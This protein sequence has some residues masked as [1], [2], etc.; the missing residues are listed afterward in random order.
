MSWRR[1]AYDATTRGTARPSVR[2]SRRSA[3][4]DAADEES[5]FRRLAAQ[6]GLSRQ[7]Q[8]TPDD[9]QDDA[10]DDA[11]RQ[12]NDEGEAEG[13][14]R[15]GDREE[16][17]SDFVGEGLESPLTPLR[18][19][20]SASESLS[21]D[22]SLP[23]SFGNYDVMRARKPPFDDELQRRTQRN[24]ERNATL[25]GS[26]SGGGGR[27]D[28]MRKFYEAQVDTI[29]AQLVVVA[30]AQEHIET[31]LQEERE[32]SAKKLQDMEV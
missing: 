6:L 31:T 32:Q 5:R 19:D 1:G 22:L 13:Y 16:E 18:S 20:Y 27:Q 10:V 9:D 4:E 28:M 15:E 17:E 11:H 26:A 2:S 7:L 24:T 29:R 23:R 21:S 8:H 25:I 12:I 3:D 30:Q 14:D